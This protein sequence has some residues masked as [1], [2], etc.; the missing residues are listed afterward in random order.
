MTLELRPGA[1]FTLEIEKV[2]GGWRLST[3]LRV[4]STAKLAGQPMIVKSEEE[5]WIGIETYAQ[6]M[7]ARRGLD[8]VKP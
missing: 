2:A 6:A 5:A 1:A 3:K 8:K 7:L 4:G